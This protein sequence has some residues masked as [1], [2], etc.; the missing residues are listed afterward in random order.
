VVTRFL[1]PI[2]LNE[3][4]R[5]VALAKEIVK[6]YVQQRGGLSLAA[7]LVYGFVRQA[8][9]ALWLGESDPEARERQ[10]SAT[11]AALIGIAPRDE[12]EGILAAQLL[13][14]TMPPWNA[15]DAR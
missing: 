6:Y 3:Q 11:V 1:S 7:A 8:D 15:T 10:Y 9:H 2:T 12:L 5:G 4:T 14:L 13:R